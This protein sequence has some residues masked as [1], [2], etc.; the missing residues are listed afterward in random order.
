MKLSLG[1]W[2][3]SFGPYAAS[4]VP[5]RTVVERASAA[6]YEGIDICGF[7]PHVSLDLYPTRL[8]RR[9]L[10]SLI[11]DHK[12]GV[13]GYSADFTDINPVIPGNETAWLDLLKRNVQMCADIH[14][15]S[16]R[17][18]TGAAPGSIPDDDYDKAFHRVAGLWAKGAELA[19][20]A[21]VRLVWEFEPGFA[22]NKPSEVVRMHQEVRHPNFSLVF[23]TS[24]A[25]MSAVAAARQHGEPEHVKGGVE[26]FLD[27]LHGR[28][29]A[30]H[31]VDS[32]GTLYHEESSTHR[33]FGEGRLDFS[34]LIP[35]LLAVPNVNWWTVD[36]AFWPGAWDLVESSRQFVL[37]CVKP[38]K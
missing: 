13:S 28:I 22:F 9:D 27:K 4:P 31:I 30:I 11:E 3:F 26:A 29:G 2:A 33:P 7:Q 25:Y 19:Q 37:K 16:L 17:I 20:S 35:R 21:G 23:D 24:H 5:F 12:L 1:S 15:P 8:S 10:V 32:D 38:G 36:L 6:G 14:S 18:D 34:R